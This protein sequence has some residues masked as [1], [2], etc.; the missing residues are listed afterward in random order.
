MPSISQPFRLTALPKIASLNNYATQ[1]NY[2]QVADTLTPTTNNINVGVS[3]SA[4]SQYIINPTPK[5][6]YNQPISSTN[7]VSACAVA[8]ITTTSE[9]DSQEVICYGIQSNRVY[10]LCATIKPV[11]STASDS[12]FGETY[13]AHKVSVSDQIVNLKVFPDTKS[14]VAVLRSGLIQFFDFELKLQHSLDSSYK[15]VSYVQHFTSESGQRYT[16]L[17]SDI[18][19]HKVSFKLFEIGQSDSATPAT[20]LSSVILENMCLKDS[21]IFYQFGQVYR[22]HGNAVSIYNLPHFQHSRTIELPFLAPE[23]IISFKPIS[24]NR[25]LLTSDNK[26]FLLDLLHNAILSQREMG[27]VKIFQLLETAVIPGNSTLNNKTIA[28][29][30][31]IKHGSNPSSSLDIINID[32][33]TGT[34]RDSMGKGFMSRENKSQH[35]QPLIS[36]LNDTEAAE[37][38]YDRILK[39]LSKAADNIENFDSVFF[40]RL[41]IK[42][43]YYTDSDRF[44]NDREFLEDVSTLIFKSF[45]SEYPKALTY[46]LTNPLFPVSHTHNLLQK[47]KDHPRLFKQAIVTCPNLLLDELVQELFTVINDELCLDLSLRILQ[48]FNKDS[49]KE[50]I[51]QKSKID[52][53]NFINFVISENFE[54]DRIKNK[55]RLFQLLSLVLDSVGLFALENEMLEKLTKYIDQQLSVVKEN[56]ELYNLVEEKNFKNGFGQPLGDTSTSGEP[57]ITAYSIEQLEL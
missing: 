30:V 32:V 55:P 45:K 10:S 49:I 57:V 14:I 39:E 40:K 12:S 41:G 35:L 8:E 9:K 50:A 44:V 37:F 23:S 47:L 53:N 38:N 15:N 5:L 33:G 36:T 18:D 46:L 25:A 48:D 29:G 16:F 7:V 43:N 52:V 54:E 24:T 17:L 27:H 19:G 4:V 31:S 42:N 56:V 26:I 13:A 3:G 2:L 6:V 1:G 34:L 28:L 20:E 51:K 11:S 21:Q 22:L